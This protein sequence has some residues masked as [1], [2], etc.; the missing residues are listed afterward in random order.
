MKIN[1]GAEFMHISRYK[2]FDSW[3]FG[4]VAFFAFAVGRVINSADRLPPDPSYGFFEDSYTSNFWVIFRTEGGYL[5]IPRR[6]LS[7]LIVLFPMRYTALLGTVIW[8]VI[9]V[10][11]A[12]IVSL[13]VCK[14]LGNSLAA[15]LCG[16]TVV[17]AP[18]ASESQVGNQSV[19]KWSLILVLIFVL[20]ASKNLKIYLKSAV[21][22]AVVTGVSNPVTFLVFGAFITLLFVRRERVIQHKYMWVVGAFIFGFLVEF[23]AWKSTGVGV[24]KY[25][26]S[27]YFLWSGAGAFWIYNFLIPPCMMIALVMARLPVFRVPYP[28][29]FVQNLS[30]YGIVLWAGTYYLGGIADRYFV[31]PQILAFSAFIVYCSENLK[32]LNRPLR[33]A[34]IF[35]AAI[36]I[37]AMVYWYQASWFLSSGPQWS[38]EIDQKVNE[39][40]NSP[41]NSITIRQF[42]GDFDLD[43]SSL[44]NRS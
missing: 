14:S 15:F 27:V 13:I 32:S 3:I 17:L 31:V 9:C 25:Q 19:I 30:F 12:L 24:H 33:I 22:A 37:F 23:F 40:L 20:S 7:E 34:C 44:L 21:L 10:S 39:C 35:F 4:V 6:L 5:D 28:S 8:A 36:G 18:S 43:C 1:F 11:S 41:I 2:F 16:L 38:L 29:V 42:M 26:D